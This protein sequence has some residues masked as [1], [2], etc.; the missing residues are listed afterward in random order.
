[1][2]FE[3][4]KLAERLDGKTFDKNHPYIQEFLGKYGHRGNPEIDIGKNPD[5]IFYLY[6][7]DLKYPELWQEKVQR[8]EEEYAIENRRTRVPRLLFN[9]GETIYTVRRP[10]CDSRVMEGMSISPGVYEGMVRIM[11]N[12]KE[13]LEKGEI[14]VTES[15]NPA[16]TPLFITAG[17]LIM[18]SGGPI[19]HGAIVA[20]EYGIPGVVG[21]PEVTTIL[22]TG[23]RVRVHGDLGI[24]EILDK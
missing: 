10:G 14:L 11:T 21:I 16:W 13:T 3:L 9:T 17:A 12:P 1:M 2:G 18:E 19:S 6:L 4:N 15:T 20:R 7:D 23:M 22:K 8:N 5:G 24:V